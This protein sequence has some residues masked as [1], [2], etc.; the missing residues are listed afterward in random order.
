MHIDT[1]VAEVTRPVFRAL[2]AQPE[3]NTD[4]KVLD[5]E[6]LLRADFVNFLG[7]A[8]DEER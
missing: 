4:R 3:L 2:L 8:V 6:D 1:H 7:F 5:S